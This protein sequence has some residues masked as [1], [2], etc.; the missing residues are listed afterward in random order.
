M[1]R[2]LVCA[3]VFAL[4]SFTTLVGED[5][6]VL[7]Q[8]SPSRKDRR[9]G[10]PVTLNG[11]HPWRSIGDLDVWKKRR[12]RVRRQVLV[13]AGLWPLPE[14][15]P[16]RPRI[17]GKVDR[18][19]YTVEK[20]FFESYP[21]F[22]VT[23]NLYRPDSPNDGQRR[24]GVLSPHGH[25]RDGR[26]YRNAEGAARK[27]VEEGKE[28][29]I[30]GARSPL[31]ARCAQL[32]RMG[33]V[34][35]HYDMVG[36]ADSRQVD[37]RSGFGDVE[38]ELRLQSWFGLQTW[39]T[40][41]A[42]DFVESLPDVDP[43]RIGV[44]GASGGGTQTF[45]LGAIDD[46]PAA[47]FPAVMVST[48]MQGG[49]VCENASHLRVG[50]S[51]VEFAAL[52]APKPYGMTGANDW[53][54]DIMTKGLPELKALWRAYGK[55]SLVE[56][57]CYRRF[58][59]NYNQVSREH[60]YGWFNEHLGLGQSSP[61]LERPFEP[62]PRELLSVFTDQHPLPDHAVDTRQLRA[63]LTATSDEQI[64]SLVPTGPRS[65]AEFR[66][67]I[68][69]GL[70]AILH[71]S[72]P[73]KGEIRSSLHGDV[74]KI[75]EHELRRMTIGRKGGGEE[76]PALLIKP[77]SW[78]GVVSLMVSTRG[79]SSCFVPG[80]EG[81]KLRSD[82]ESLLGRGAAILSIDS[83]LTGEYLAAARADEKNDDLEDDE[84][85]AK[86][87]RADRGRQGG[88]VGYTL[89]YNRTLLGQRVHDI[90]TAVGYARS[91]AGVRRV[92]LGGLE[93]A[94]SWAILARAL[95]GDAIDRTLAT[96]RAR[97]DFEGMAML[98]DASFVPGGRKY[99]G[100]DAFAALCAPAEM[101]LVGEPPPS[102]LM[103]SAYLAAGK[104]DSLRHLAVLDRELTEELFDWFCN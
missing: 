17:H 88:F 49:C 73:A 4:V 102:D 37:H 54:K 62:L 67:V 51:N 35:F 90:L 26:F 13:A 81:A 87:Y 5:V 66:R 23:G 9:L 74:A 97:I 21:G 14:K 6:S 3:T 99:G 55:E 89:G 52:A 72:M 10:D 82:V 75:G 20:V 57:W 78:T 8:P 96:L 39:N 70:E 80:S 48:D 33:C 58:E 64:R 11:Y 19:D 91:L 92:N 47:L 98:D 86:L 32:A 22:F 18:G 27:Q 69:G 84:L 31:Q 94:G 15:T 76:V 46:R 42:Y 63:Y 43:S 79:K 38:A 30:Q 83:F 100:M 7:G 40:I 50:T 61:V 2:P 29:R 68:G 25:W 41:R 1:T 59:H 93:G 65:L 71:T 36:Y 53:T 95:S 77:K 34:V 45:I 12:E 101:S 16:L 44:T 24:A 60:M 56:A 85:A 28:K 104:A 103:K